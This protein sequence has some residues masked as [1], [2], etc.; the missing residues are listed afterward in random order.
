MKNFLN[1]PLARAQEARIENPLAH[2]GINNIGDLIG[3]L[4]NIA[5]ALVGLAA[6]IALIIAGYK[7]I[8]AGGNESRVKEATQQIKWALFGLILV[9]LAF[10]IVRVIFNTL[11]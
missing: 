6:A 5:L 7:Y 2:V 10:T 11:N 4:I 1:I 3:Y 8:M 9:L